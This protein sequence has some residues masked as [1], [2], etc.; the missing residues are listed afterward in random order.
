M[1]VS[2]ARVVL[3]VS[4]RLLSDGPER[5]GVSPC[6]PEITGEKTGMERA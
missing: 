6:V 2:D 1:L 3:P 5:S 4:K